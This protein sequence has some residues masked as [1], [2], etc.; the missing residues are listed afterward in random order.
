MRTFPEQSLSISDKAFANLSVAENLQALR[1]HGFTHLHFAHKWTHPEPMSSEELELWQAALVTTGM[2][3]LDVHGCHPKEMN[4]WSADPERREA[5]IQRML[6]RLRITH[7]LGGDA[8]VYHVPCHVAPTQQVLSWFIDGLRQVEDLACELKINIALENH[9]LNENDKRTLELAF[10]TFDEAFVGFTFDPGHA[11]I[12]GNFEWILANCGP[13]LRILHLNDN[14]GTRDH[15]WNPHDPCG[16]ANWD[17]IVQFIS[18]SPYS[19]PIQL[20]VCWSPD[21]HGGHGQ[22]LMEAARAGRKIASE[23]CAYG[24]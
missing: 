6:H 20:E 19:K 13:R 3:V 15:H 1:D 5:A 24:T 14:D 21:H 22:F 16:L 10:E 11:L 8:M 7:A 23:V 2:R 4:L 12:S 17:R 18:E 9:Y